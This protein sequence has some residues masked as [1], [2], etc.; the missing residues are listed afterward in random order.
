MRKMEAKTAI[1]ENIEP[2]DGLIREEKEALDRYFDCNIEMRIFRLSFC[3]EKISNEEELKKLDGNNSFLANATIIN[4]KETN[5]WHSYI[6]NAIVT[7]PMM[8][9]KK[10]EI[11]HNFIPLLNNYIYSIK[12]F[13]CQIKC[14]DKDI[15]TYKIFGSY[16]CQ[17]NSFTSV[18]GHAA[19]CMTINNTDL[20]KIGI[21]TAEH[22]NKFLLIDHKSK[23]ISENI[24]ILDTDIM[25]FLESM[26]LSVVGKNFFENNYDGKP[27]IDYSEYL[28]R[29]IES[30]HPCLLIFTT[31]EKNVMHIVP[32]LGHTL[33]TDLWK[34]EAE[35]A[36]SNTVETEALEFNYRSASAWVDHFLIHDDNFGMYS[37]LPVDLLRRTTSFKS[38]PSFRAMKAIIIKPKNE[39]TPALEAEK[40]SIEIMK[41]N[42]IDVINSSRDAVNFWI[43]E[44]AAYVSNKLNTP[45]VVRTLLVTKEDYHKNLNHRDFGDIMFTIEEKKEIMEGLPEIFWLT[46]ITLPDLYTANKTKLVDIFYKSDADKDV[47]EENWIQTRLPGFLIKKSK[48]TFVPLG[49]SSHYPLFR[50]KEAHE[51]YEW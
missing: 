11:Y 10:K 40:N 37:C 44:L 21:I 38:E 41:D 2:H 25:S 51:I 7:I 27:V 42:I 23:R 46:E 24:N 3:I 20:S 36:Y 22:L 5:S 34:P 17:Q 16:F 43:H 28:Y 29:Y 1:V 50:F 26:G 14:S 9:P 18:C 19:L 39:K 12:M 48:K 15:Y 33:N 8:K 47:R 32:I 45:F 30:R 4:F 35:I 6:F 13:D 31:K 49:V